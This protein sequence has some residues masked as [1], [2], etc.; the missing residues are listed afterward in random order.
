MPDA[1]ADTGWSHCNTLEVVDSWAKPALKIQAIPP[2]RHQLVVITDSVGIRTVLICPIARATT[3]PPSPT[4][5]NPST[6]TA[7]T[8][9]IAA[10]KPTMRSKE[11]LKHHRLTPR[12][13]QQPSYGY[14]SGDAYGYGDSDSSSPSSSSKST[15]TGYE[16]SPR[17]GGA[18]DDYISQST[19]DTT[20]STS[21]TP[22]TQQS[23]RSTSGLS[24]SSTPASSSSRSSSSTSSSSSQGQQSPKTASTTPLKSQHSNSEEISSSS[25]PSQSSNA[26]KESHEP[27]DHPP[28][29]IPLVKS[30]SPPPPPPP[31]PPSPSSTTAPAPAPTATPTNGAAGPGLQLPSIPGITDGNNP[32]PE[33]QKPFDIS[34]LL[35][36]GGSSVLGGG[37]TLVAI[38][39]LV[40]YLI[41]RKNG[42][43]GSGDGGNGSVEGKTSDLEAGLGSMMASAGVGQ[44]PQQQ[45]FDNEGDNQPAPT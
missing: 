21:G 27:N 3:I 32:G 33:A 24:S 11:Q 22:S 31:S 44:Q 29:A 7:A 45:N 4:L 14:S 30:S 20:Y 19:S 25:T 41:R 5:S 2:E 12:N 1:V 17:T 36:I 38:F 9:P 6:L 10:R 23:F 34:N 26:V 16:S 8:S 18:P 42:K 28:P 40:K 39:F 37:L 13:P 15:Y 43:Q 35:K